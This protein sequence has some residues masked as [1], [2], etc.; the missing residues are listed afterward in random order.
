M[1]A[2]SAEEFS[3]RMSVEGDVAIYA[4]LGLSESYQLAAKEFASFRLEFQNGQIP[5]GVHSLP[6]S[7]QIDQYVAVLAREL[8]TYVGKRRSFRIRV[9][10]VE[11]RS[12]AVVAL[13]YLRDDEQV[14][15]EPAQDI[16]LDAFDETGVNVFQNS[17]WLF[18]DHSVPRIS[19]VKPLSRAH[20]TV[21]RAFAD[22]E[23]II[24]ESSAVP[25]VQN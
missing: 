20:W 19:V 3:I 17:A 24:V 11:Q 25:K 2:S 16:A 1:S 22:A 12:I 14:P 21:E 13:D 18:R 5:A 4:A 7:A 15:I 8:A 23:R 10:R 9:N 6:E